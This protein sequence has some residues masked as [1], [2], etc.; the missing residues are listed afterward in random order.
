M[1]HLIKNETEIA[2]LNKI[3]PRKIPA[4]VGGRIF[5][6]CPIDMHSK[7]FLFIDPHLF[8]S[9]C[10]NQP[11]FSAIFDGLSTPFQIVRA[12]RETVFIGLVR[13]EENWHCIQTIAEQYC[14]GSCCCCH[15]H[16]IKIL[17]TFQTYRHQPKHSCHWTCVYLFVLYQ[18]FTMF[19]Q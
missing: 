16:S 15:W 8:I 1:I 5:S 11:Y 19:C 4:N 2:F 7:K 3:I 9:N 17:T 18:Y 10:E 14:L 13:R 12:G 6:G